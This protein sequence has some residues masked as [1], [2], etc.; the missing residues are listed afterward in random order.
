MAEQQVLTFGEFLGKLALRTFDP[1]YV[2]KK[3]LRKEWVV[4]AGAPMVVGALVFQQSA[5]LGYTRSNSAEALASLLGLELNDATTPYAD[6]MRDLVTAWLENLKGTP[7]SLHDVWT[8]AAF[9]EV[10]LASMAT[11]EQMAKGELRVAVLMARLTTAAVYGVAYG[12]AFG[13]ELEEL[14]RKSFETLR[15]EGDWKRARSAGLAIPAQQ[16]IYPL[17]DAQTAALHQTALYARE[18][19]PDLL[20]PLDLTN[21]GVD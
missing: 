11:W 2:R 17:A 12:M 16:E 19:R 20:D 4:P 9:P 15:G 5:V 3:L 10:D 18:F 6:A 13:S 7:E 21:Y 8:G 14:W 1:S